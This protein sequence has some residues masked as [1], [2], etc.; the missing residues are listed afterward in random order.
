MNVLVGGKGG[1]ERVIMCVIY[2]KDESRI[3]IE[4]LNLDFWASL[5]FARLYNETWHG[6]EIGLF[7]LLPH[8]RLVAE[9]KTSP[10]RCKCPR[11]MGVKLLSWV[12]LQFWAWIWKSDWTDCETNKINRNRIVSCVVGY[13][14]V[15]WENTHSGG[16]T[17][18]KGD[19]EGGWSDSWE[20]HLASVRGDMARQ[21]HLG[22]TQ[23]ERLDPEEVTIGNKTM[24]Q[25]VS[26]SIDMVTIMVLSIACKTFFEL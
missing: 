5:I 18:R 25:E 4:Y 3:V 14:N 6:L 7:K 15:I 17:R 11:V 10:Q 21:Q 9:T 23:G 26:L 24:Q 13:R 16:P 12:P 2:L 20:W 22:Q 8:P 19:L 1:T